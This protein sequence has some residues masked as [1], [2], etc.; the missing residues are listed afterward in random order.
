[1]SWEDFKKAY[2]AGGD[3]YR[4]K[5]S[6]WI[7]LLAVV[8]AL[9]IDICRRHGVS[10]LGEVVVGALIVILLGVFVTLAV[11]GNRRPTLPR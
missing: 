8:I 2:A 3:T 7:V 11:R 10:R 9:T 6:R 5:R 1:M 4:E